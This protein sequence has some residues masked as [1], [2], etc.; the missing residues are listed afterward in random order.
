VIMI[1]GV[2]DTLNA[3]AGI[4]AYLE[5]FGDRPKLPLILSGLVDGSGRMLCG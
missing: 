5:Y 2:L 3:K 4:F 1:E